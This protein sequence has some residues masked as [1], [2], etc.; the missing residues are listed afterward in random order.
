VTYLGEDFES[1]KKEFQKFIAEKE[2]REK[3]LVFRE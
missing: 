2:E 3:H 1:I